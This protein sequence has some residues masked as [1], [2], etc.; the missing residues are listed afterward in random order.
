MLPAFVHTSLERRTIRTADLVLAAAD[1]DWIPVRRSWRLNGRHYGALQGRRKAE[2]LDEYGEERFPA[3]RRPYDIS[4]PRSARRPGSPSSAIRVTRRYRPRRG[5]TL[6]PDALG[7][8]FL[9]PHAASDAIKAIR[10]QG[11]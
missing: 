3:W 8:Q 11:R 2:V 7:G 9:D 1:G 5:R 6:R 4:P 10:N